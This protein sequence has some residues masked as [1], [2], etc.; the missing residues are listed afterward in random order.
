MD[1]IYM[2][3]TI[4]NISV[5]RRECADG[6]DRIGSAVRRLFC[7]AREW[8]ATLGAEERELP[9]SPSP[10]LPPSLSRSR[11]RSICLYAENF[12]LSKI[13][14]TERTPLEKRARALAAKA[15]TRNRNASETAR[16]PPPNRTRNAT[17]TRPICVLFLFA[18]SS[19]TKKTDIDWQQ[20]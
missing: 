10:A 17:E 7:G 9:L 8:V 15:R 3:I 18:Q 14:T 16:E 4:P 13:A 12:S 6:S 2:C 19:M 11:S 5:G 20:E 1:G